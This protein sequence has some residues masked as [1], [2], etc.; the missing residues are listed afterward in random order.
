MVADRFVA[1]VGARAL[2]E[3]WAPQVAEVVRFLLGRGW[4]IGSGGA[5]GA[6]EYALRAVLKAGRKACS[7]SVVFLPGALADSRSG[8]LR[9]FIR[10]GG[11]VVEGSGSGR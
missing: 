6:D 10:R 11:R 7:R 1:V 3:A 9:A 2:P 4:G 5:R 8:L